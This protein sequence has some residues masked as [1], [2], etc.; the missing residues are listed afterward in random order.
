MEGMRTGQ[1]Q[2]Y[3]RWLGVM[4]VGVAM[5]LGV[6]CKSKPKKQRC[7]NMTSIFFHKSRMRKYHIKQ[8][9]KNHTNK[10][11]CQSQP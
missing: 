2:G 10:H 1:N 3:W 11:P 6:G 7:F 9:N 8:G 4:A 5:G